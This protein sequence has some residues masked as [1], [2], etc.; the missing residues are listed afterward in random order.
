VID[1]SADTEAAVAVL[2]VAGGCVSN[3]QTDKKNQLF[4]KDNTFFI[5]RMTAPN[6]I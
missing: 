6:L 4:L 1:D 2:I 5:H 3:T